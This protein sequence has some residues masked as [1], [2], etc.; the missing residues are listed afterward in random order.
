MLV[1]IDWLA[2]QQTKATATTAKKVVQLLNYAT[3][4]PNAVIHYHASGM[5]LYR[6]SDAS[7]LSEP[8]TNKSHA[9]SHFFLSDKPTDPSQP[10]TGQPKLSGAIH[11]TCKIL[12]NVMAS[13]AEAEVAGLF[14]NAQEAVLIRTML[15]E[16]GH[17]QPPTPLQADNS[18]TT[19]FANNTIKQKR[20]KAMDMQFY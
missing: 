14:L 19:G 20:S 1:A 3:I 5:V 18:T 9:S 7:Y 2:S 15:E 17:P 11:T 6:H 4:H 16:L 13:A 10:P 12:R 8:D